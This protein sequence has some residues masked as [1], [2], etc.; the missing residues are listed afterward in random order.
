MTFHAFEVATDRSSTIHVNLSQHVADQHLTHAVKTAG[1]DL[2]TYAVG[3][4][5]AG[6]VEE[7]IDLLR[8][9][10]WDYSQRC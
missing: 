6:S 9:G 8:Q 10:K 4:V 2:D 3:T 7:A 5:E 1:K